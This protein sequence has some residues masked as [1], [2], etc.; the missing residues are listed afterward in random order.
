VALALSYQERDKRDWLFKT[1][2]VLNECYVAYC[3]YAMIQM[4]TVTLIN[5]Q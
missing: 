1:E 5:V 2:Q 4:H 3:L